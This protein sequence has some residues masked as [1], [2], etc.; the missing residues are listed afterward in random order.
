MVLPMR[1][2]KKTIQENFSLSKIAEITHLK[3][4]ADSDLEYSDLWEHL[5]TLKAWFW[6]SVIPDTALSLCRACLSC[7]ASKLLR[8]KP[9]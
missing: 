3:L 6:L 4:E 2:K 1:T 5:V 8:L 7:S 9:I